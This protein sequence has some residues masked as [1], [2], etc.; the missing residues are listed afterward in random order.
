MSST[1]TA[2]ITLIIIPSGTLII[3]ITHKIYT[4]MNADQKKWLKFQIECK[5]RRHSETT[6]LQLKHWIKEDGS[7][8]WNTVNSKTFHNF[9]CRNRKKFQDTGSMKRKEGT[10]GHNQISL[11]KKVKIK[12]LAA[13]KLYAGTRPVAAKVG[14]SAETVR[15][16]LKRSGH[17]AYHKRKVQAMT[18]E[19]EG[20]RVTCSNWLL[21][22]YGRRVDG[23]TVW[24]RLLNTDWSG[25]N[26]KQFFLSC[27]I[28]FRLFF[29]QVQSPSMGLS[30]PR[31]M[32]SGPSLS[33]MPGNCWTVPRRSSRRT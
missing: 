31:M 23:R 22:N 10:G 3:I 18:P 26:L 30:T 21:D 11:A 8:D 17:K 5:M 1:M 7:Q 6:L 15:N 25:K 20:R 13:N 28:C 24:G 27:F 32:L 2:P 12:R 14:V 4:S 16:E 29:I 33:R 9:V 19:Q